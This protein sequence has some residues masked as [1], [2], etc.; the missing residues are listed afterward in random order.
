MYPSKLFKFNLFNRCDLL[1]PVILENVDFPSVSVQMHISLPGADLTISTPYFLELMRFL[2]SL[3]IESSLPFQNRT[4]FSNYQHG[5]LSKTGFDTFI[6][7]SSPEQSFPVKAQDFDNST[8]G[9]VSIGVKI[10]G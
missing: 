6:D 10:K 3:S 5:H 8:K 2:D 1:L 4:L 7:T 9:V